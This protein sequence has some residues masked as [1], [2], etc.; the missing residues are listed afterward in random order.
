MINIKERIIAEANYIIETKS[1][2]REASNKFKISKTTLHK[3]IHEKLEKI[4]KELYS[5]I[6]DIMEEHLNN[7]SIKGGQSTKNKYNKKETNYEEK[8]IYSNSK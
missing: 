3:D 6:Q 4:N 7:R 5:S 8:N 1:T 2:I